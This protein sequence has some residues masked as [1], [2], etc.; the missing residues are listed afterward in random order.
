MTPQ[1]GVAIPLYQRGRYVINVGSVGQPRDE[2]NASS[3]AVYD[4]EEKDVTFYRVAYDYTATAK[5][6][7]ERG[8]PALFAERLAKGH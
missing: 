1:P 4:T 3:F 7:I 2:I 5:K 8:L 6:I